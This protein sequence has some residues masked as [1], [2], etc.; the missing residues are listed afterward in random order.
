M[1]PELVE[2]T[3]RARELFED[4]ELK[5]VR[6]WKEAVPGRKAVGHMPIYVPRELIHAAGML[7]VVLCPVLIG[8]EKSWR[9][10]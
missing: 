2:L 8:M 9:Y 6:A 5:A 10:L 4:L 3:N 1:S 7:P